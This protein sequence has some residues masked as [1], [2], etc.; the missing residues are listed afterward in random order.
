M[1]L[2]MNRWV[3]TYTHFCESYVLTYER[4]DIDLCSE[5]YVFIHELLGLV[6]HQC[7][8]SHVSNYELLDIDLYTSIVE[9]HVYAHECWVLI[10]T[11]SEPESSIAA[12]DPKA[13]AEL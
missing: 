10:Y 9:S 8:E 7:C 12:V 4:L 6:L 2:A 5:S 11:S 3:W 1:F 13:T